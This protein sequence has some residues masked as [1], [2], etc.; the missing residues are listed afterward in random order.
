MCKWCAGKRWRP[1]FKQNGGART[2]NWKPL[3]SSFQRRLRHHGRRKIRGCSQ[4]NCS[5]SSHTTT[6]W[7]QYKGI[8]FKEPSQEEVEDVIPHEKSLVRISAYINIAKRWNVPFLNG[9][10][11]WEEVIA[12]LQHV[13]WVT[14]KRRI[15]IKSFV[16]SPWGANRNERSFPVTI[17]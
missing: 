17:I 2:I 11:L 7:Q 16:L 5:K 13:E 8:D 14:T 15:L 10:L 12:C 3:P 9:P 4:C 6:W 1:K